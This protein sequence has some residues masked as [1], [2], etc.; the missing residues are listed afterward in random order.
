MSG[1]N[2]TFA[3]CAYKK[4]DYLEE[5][6]KSLINQTKKSEILIATS[7]PNE[8][9]YGLA[10][11]YSIPVFVNGGVAGIAGDWNFGYSKATTEYVTIAH[12][13]DVYEPDYAEKIIKKSLHIIS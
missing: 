3:L 12:Q 13:D 5:C 8:F 6:I 1:T 4:S 2:H 11:K 7:T 10:E 9:I